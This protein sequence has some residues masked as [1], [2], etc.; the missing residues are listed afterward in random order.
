MWARHPASPSH[1]FYSCRRFADSGDAAIPRQRLAVIYTHG[2][3]CATTLPVKIEPYNKQRRVRGRRRGVHP[4]S[5]RLFHASQRTLCD[6]H[7]EIYTDLDW[8]ISSSFGDAELFFTV[9][10]LLGGID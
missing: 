3:V 7:Q 10:K 1:A 5:P 6:V 4:L 9:V 8:P 2:P